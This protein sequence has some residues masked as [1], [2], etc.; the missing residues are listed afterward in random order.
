MERTRYEYSVPCLFVGLWLGGRKIKGTYN[1]T[2]LLFLG[3]APPIELDLSPGEH[4]RRLSH[5]A[6]KSQAGDGMTG[7][8]TKTSSRGIW[9]PKKPLVSSEDYEGW[10]VS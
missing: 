7:K 5:Y 1:A 4:R 8:I 2:R 6:K 9:P 10:K 3:L